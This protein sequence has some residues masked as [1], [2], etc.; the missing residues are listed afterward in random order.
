MKGK[1]TPRERALLAVGAVGLIV[2]LALTGLLLY[3][4][5]TA[6]ATTLRWWA[7]LATAALPLAGIL[8]YYLG[9]M[10]VRGHVAGLTQGIEAVSQAAQKTTEVAQRAADIRVSTAQ[11]MREQRRPAVQPTLQQAFLLPGGG[12]PFG[13]SSGVIVEAPQGEGEVEV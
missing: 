11:R 10:E 6:D 12:M 2:I 5:L 7:G 8:A 3:A 9:R 1:L 13:S 4:V